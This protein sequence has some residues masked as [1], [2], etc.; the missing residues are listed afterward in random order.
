MHDNWRCD[1]LGRMWDP[2]FEMAVTKVWNLPSRGHPE[3][4]GRVIHGEVV[5]GQPVELVDD[6]DVVPVPDITVEFHPR[7]GEMTVVLF[8]VDPAHV[9][10]GQ[11]LRA[12]TRWPEYATVRFTT[13]SYAASGIDRGSLGTIV[14]V[15]GTYYAV[16]ATDRDQGT[17]LGFVADRDLELVQEPG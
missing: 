3:V 14:S 12:V 11:R 4:G 7:T 16:E 10:P 5:S 9:R 17:F 6:Q 8:H 15:H 2:T 13:D 1:M